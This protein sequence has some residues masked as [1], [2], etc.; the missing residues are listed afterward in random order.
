[1]ARE[2]D[3]PLTKADLKW[4]RE[5]YSTAYVDRM[6]A[7]HGT[8]GGKSEDDDARAEAEEAARKEQEAADAADEAARAAATGSPGGS[9]PEGENVPENGG[10]GSDEDLIGGEVFPVT[11]KTE[12]E[13]KEWVATASDEDKAVALSLEKGREDREPRKGVLALLGE[14]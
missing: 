10:D 9:N 2:F 6:I 5:R 12:S 4:L 1:M 3:G 11:D 14:S 13:V 7:L 8:K